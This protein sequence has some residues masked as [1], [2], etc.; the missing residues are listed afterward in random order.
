MAKEDN[1]NTL[2]AALLLED[3][4]APV[5]DP[6]GKPKRKTRKSDIIREPLAGESGAE[7]KKKR[8]RRGKP[9]ELR[10]SHSFTVLMT[11]QMYQKFK[12]ITENEGVSMNGVITKLLRKYII[13]HDIDDDLLDI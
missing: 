7:L 2:A 11:E 9:A 13:A 1:K 6:A 5:P 4:G 8:T 12:T 10:K 3:V